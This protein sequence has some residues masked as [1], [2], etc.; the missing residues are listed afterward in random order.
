MKPT[1][2]QASLRV[3]LALIIGVLIIGAPVFAILLIGSPLNPWTG[4]PELSGGSIL[5]IL[6]AL[7]CL[8]GLSLLA[9]YGATR[10]GAN[11]FEDLAA[12]IRRIA[13][14]DFR[15]RLGPY[16]FKEPHEML[17]I[18]DAFNA[19]ATELQRSEELRNNLMADVSHELRTPLT[20]LEGNLRAALDHVYPLDEAEIANL[21]GQTRHLIRLVNDL[22]ELALADARQLPLVLAPTDPAELIDDTAQI[23]APLA[24]ERGVALQVTT[25]HLPAI[26]VDAVRM[27]QV[28]YNMLSNALRHTPRGGEIRVHSALDGPA[29]VI[30]VSDTGDGLERE[31]I[32]SV[33]DR[34][35]RAD[36]SR[37]RDTGGTGLGLAIVSALVTM[38]GGAVAAA[39]DGRGMGSTFTIRLPLAADVAEGAAPAPQ[40]RAE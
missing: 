26:H 17:K 25:A 27:R 23:F 7:A 29:V 20:A 2:A 8:G 36:R 34:F 37:S 21:Y 14:G 32:A 12:S 31:Q 22:H 11:P 40:L 18:A 16:K 35:Y 5:R 9:G 4:A 3:M 33:F 10:G 30:A 19:M 6:G 28:L 1:W 15:V 13:T 24:E 38:H 39:S